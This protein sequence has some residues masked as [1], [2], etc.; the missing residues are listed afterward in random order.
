MFILSES[1]DEENTNLEEAKRQRTEDLVSHDNEHQP[2]ETQ[3][4]MQDRYRLKWKNRTLMV[5]VFVSDSRELVDGIDALPKGHARFRLTTCFL[6]ALIKWNG[7]KEGYHVVGN[8][9][10][11][12]KRFS[13]KIIAPSITSANLE[14]EPS[15]NLRKTAEEKPMLP[16]CQCR[17]K[18]SHFLNEEQRLKIHRQYWDGFYDERRTWLLKHVGKV[19]IERRRIRNVKVKKAKRNMAVQFDDSEQLDDDKM[20]N[21]SDKEND[22]DEDDNGQGEYKK[23]FSRKY[24]L[25]SGNDNLVQVCK[26]MFMATLGYTSD[27]FITVALSSK[28][29]TNQ[30]G[31]HDH[32]YHT[33]PEADDK[34]MEDHIQ[35]YEP[36][37]SHYRREHAPHVLYVDPSLTVVDM[38]ASY[39]EYAKKRGMKPSS[40]STYRRKLKTL[41]ISFAKLGHEQCESCLK[42]EEHKCLSDNVRSCRCCEKGKR[43]E[44]CKLFLQSELKMKKKKLVKSGEIKCL[45]EDVCGCCNEHKKVVIAK[46]KARLECSQCS[47][48]VKHLERTYIARSKYKADKQNSQNSNSKVSLYFS[49]DLQKVRMIPEIPGV[50]SASFTQR[51]CAFNESFAPLGKKKDKP[52]AILWHQGTAGRNDE[53]VVSAF[54]KFFSVIERDTLNLVLW[55]DNCSAQNKNWTLYPALVAEVN[56]DENDLETITLNYFEAGH[57]YMSADSFHHLVEKEVGQQGHVYDFREFVDCVRN[58]GNPIVME[59]YDFKNW[60]KQLSEGKESKRTRPLLD[61]VVVAQFRKGSTNL[62]FKRSHTETEFQN[63]NFMKKKFITEVESDEVNPS[64]SSYRGIDQERKQGIIQK[65][66]PMIPSNRHSF[67]LKLKTSA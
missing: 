16:G 57:T 19:A 48:Q 32:A 59:K 56:S 24:H 44:C 45:E 8:V 21:E 35:M 67:W 31:K 40:D 49:L 22:I 15:Q 51:I 50:K 47:Y 53:D 4:P 27:K 42:Y 65:L 52:I 3:V 29:T 20:Y 12:P 33:L 6:N 36:G 5:G 38:Y 26:K 60:E 14:K 2:T 55:M 58:V 7:F 37:I 1:E 61:D 9:I 18:C 30:K 17:G 66:L 11:W 46:D 28:K 10:S 64:I 39:V 62:Y 63:S 41:N 34:L 13:K 23:R 54:F 43:C 25:D